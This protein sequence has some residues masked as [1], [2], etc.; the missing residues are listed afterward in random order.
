M[1]CVKC[2]GRY[3]CDHTLN[4]KNMVIRNRHCPKCGNKIISI[5][6]E[7][8]Y[9]EGLEYLSMGYKELKNERNYHKNNKG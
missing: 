5:E 4:F 6:K 9:T 2:G 7:M 3:Y 1:K 8:E